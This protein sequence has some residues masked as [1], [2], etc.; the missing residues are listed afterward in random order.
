MLDL[1]L[2]IMIDLAFLSFVIIQG[3]R[4]KKKINEIFGI[5][6]KNFLET[7]KNTVV[8]FLVLILISWLILTILT[9]IKINDTYKV[10]ETLRYLIKNAP[11]FLIYLLVIRTF[12]EEIFFRVFLTEKIGILLS[13]LLF[14]LV[15]IGYNSIVEII[16]A[17][18][19]GYVLAH[20]YLKTKDIVAIYLSHVLF[21]IT[22]ILIVVISI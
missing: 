18:F 12:V 3:L 6:K 8:V 15:H 19:L 10:D 13:S 11:Y 16:A 4:E 20:F 14:A 17:F 2:N 7:L 5:Y 1:I 21:N 22:N 9:M